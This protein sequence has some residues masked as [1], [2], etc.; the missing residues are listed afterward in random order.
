MANYNRDTGEDYSI[1]GS[2]FKVGAALFTGMA[3][4]NTAQT[5]RKNSQKQD[6]QNQIANCDRRINELSSGFLGSW[7]NSDQIEAEKKKRTE[8]QKKYN[9]I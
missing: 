6:I 8:L 7:L 3:V 1:A 5:G 4:L 9:N 2:L